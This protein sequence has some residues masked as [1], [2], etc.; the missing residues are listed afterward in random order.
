MR[1]LA[2]QASKARWPGIAATGTL[3]GMISFHIPINAETRHLKRARSKPQGKFTK[4]YD[5]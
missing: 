5:Y 2:V 1:W 4:K 3:A